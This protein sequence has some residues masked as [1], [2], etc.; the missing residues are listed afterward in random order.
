MPS[1]C[2][3]RRSRDRPTGS[4]F[5]AVRRSSLPAGPR[6]GLRRSRSDRLGWNSGDDR[7]LDEVHPTSFDEPNRSTCRPG[8]G[9]MV[10]GIELLIGQQI[11]AVDDAL[12]CHAR[13]AGSELPVRLCFR[14][15]QARRILLAARRPG[16]LPEYGQV[17]RRRAPFAGPRSGRGWGLRCIR[18]GKAFALVTRLIVWR[19]GW[20]VSP[21]AAAA[22]VSSKV[23]RTSSRT[24]RG[25]SPGS[26]FVR[27]VGT[28]L[29]ILV[30]LCDTVR[31]RRPGWLSEARP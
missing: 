30:A 13:R 17:L 14:R 4:S 25:R 22:R 28:Q 9:R 6:P 16:P 7:A 3:F 19:C 29:S 10:D 15:S 31:Q 8:F 2:R 23:V 18:E 11:L 20:T 24:T 21:S 12:R 5:R 1:A 27:A 26:A